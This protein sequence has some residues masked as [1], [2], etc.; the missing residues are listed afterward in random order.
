MKKKREENFCKRNY[1]EAWDYLKESKNYIWIAAAI[2]ILFG[3][4]GF[5]FPI[6]FVNEIK[7]FV[8]QLIEA[9]RGFNTWQMIWFIFKNN[10]LSGFFGLI[11]GLI[12]GIFPIFSAGQTLST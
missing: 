11:F 9:T 6:F 7:L 1:K 8:E 10:L 5:I 3:I 4:L 2:F 12:F